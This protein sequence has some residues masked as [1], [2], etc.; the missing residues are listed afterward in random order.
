MSGRELAQQINI[1]QS[2]ISRIES[3]RTIP[4]MPEVTDWVDA[5]DASAD[6]RHLLVTLTEQAHTEVQTWRHAL[7][8]QPHMQ[9]T[10][11]NWELQARASY[12]FQPSVVP[13]LLQ[14]AGYARRV[15]SMFQLP[16]GKEDIAAALAARLDRQLVLYD[17]DRTFHFLIAEAAL[18]WR[19]GPRALLI[20]QLDRICSLSTL[21]NVSIGIVPLDQEAVAP[22]SHGFVIFEPQDQEQPDF[23][24][25][26]TIHANLK[27]HGPAEVELY[28]SRWGLLRSAAL[29]DDAARRFLDELSAEIRAM[30]Q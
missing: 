26:E 9:D 13:G 25:V 16:Y 2:K 24:A 22:N 11:Q 27:V 23:V 7:Q 5:V 20:A 18:R 14:T 4:T 30:P 29:F 21:T 8:D 19:P 6:T 28:R 3:G 17:E 12:T 15:F 10:V 1:S